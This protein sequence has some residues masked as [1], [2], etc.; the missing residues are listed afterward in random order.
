MTNPLTFDTSIQPQGVYPGAFTQQAGNLAA[1]Q[2]TP[3]YPDLA[4]ANVLPGI[5]VS[6]P[7]TQYAMGAQ[8]GRDMAGAQMA[9]PQMAWAHALTNAQNQL[10]GEVARDREALGW[11]GLAAQNQAA[12]QQVDL[13]GQGNLLRLLASVFN[14]WR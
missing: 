10:G 14:Q 9:R 1:A 12:A 6:S 2:A 5:S 4:A 7:M 3:A 13:T 8:Y 11:G